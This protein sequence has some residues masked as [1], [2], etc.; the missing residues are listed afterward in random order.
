MKFKHLFNTSVEL[1]Q[2]TLWQGT[3]LTVTTEGF[4]ACTTFLK[5]HL[6]LDESVIIERA[7]KTQGLCHSQQIRE[8]IG[9]FILALARMGEKNLALWQSSNSLDITNVNLK[10]PGGCKNQYLLLSAIDFWYQPSFPILLLTAWL[11][12]HFLGYE[13]F[14]PHTSIQDEKY[15]N[16]TAMLNL[17]GSVQYF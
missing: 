13:F 7:L 9:C 5:D 15:P 12:F 1:N 2:S 8:Y 6:T 14:S 3:K 17:K 11:L 10:L 16:P 4:H